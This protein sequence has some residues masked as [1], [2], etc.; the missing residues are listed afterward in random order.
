MRE[1]REK[2]EKKEEEVKKEARDKQ[3]RVNM[4]AKK[5][6]EEVARVEMERVEKARVEKEERA[7]EDVAK[8]DVAKKA[9]AAEA[10]AAEAA[11]TTVASATSMDRDT[12]TALFGEGEAGRDRKGPREQGVVAVIAAASVSE[13]TAKVG[14]VRSVRKRFA[15]L[16]GLR[17]FV[18]HKHVEGWKGHHPF[19]NC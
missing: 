3:E 13:G 1:E 12:A 6:R 19:N 2:K 16:T 8:K 17:G 7:R 10:L 4:Q 14:F 15:R 9:L 11:A 18:S 5:E